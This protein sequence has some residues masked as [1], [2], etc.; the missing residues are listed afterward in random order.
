MKLAIL[1]QITGK[2]AAAARADLPRGERGFLRRAI[3]RAGKNFLAAHDRTKHH[4][5]TT[6]MMKIKTTCRGVIALGLT[7]ALVAPAGGADP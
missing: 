4:R 1:M 6:E 3:D 5:E 2:T 7:T